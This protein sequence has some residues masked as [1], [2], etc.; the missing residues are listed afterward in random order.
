MLGGGGGNMPEEEEE[1][2]KEDI[3][4]ILDYS[5]DGGRE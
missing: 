4:T 2:E 1:E 5:N 3:E